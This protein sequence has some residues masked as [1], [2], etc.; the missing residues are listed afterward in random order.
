MSSSSAV[1]ATPL[2]P[3]RLQASSEVWNDVLG[4]ELDLADL[5]VPGHEA[6][7]EEPAEPF[8]LAPVIDRVRGLDLRPHL[9]RCAG[10]RILH[11]P[12]AIDRPLVDRERGVGIQRVLLGVFRRTERLPE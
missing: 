6:L 8:E 9:L 5:L 1:M 12:H 10:Q 2:L 4:K 3:T 11:P 7:V